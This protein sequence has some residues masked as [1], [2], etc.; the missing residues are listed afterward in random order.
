MMS[1]IYFQFQVYYIVYFYSTSSHLIIRSTLLC[2][3]TL[4][5][6]VMEPW[7]VGGDTRELSISAMSSIF[8]TTGRQGNTTEVTKVILTYS[9]TGFH[10]TTL[11]FLLFQWLWGLLYFIPWNVSFAKIAWNSKQRCGNNVWMF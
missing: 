9:H 1:I 10:A 8:A 2:Y 7:K 11:N 5:A 6:V 3:R 4:L